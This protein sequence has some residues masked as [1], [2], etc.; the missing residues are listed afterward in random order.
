VQQNGL[1]ATVATNVAAAFIERSRVMWN[2]EPNCFAGVPM[3]TGVLI[4][5][6]R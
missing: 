4:D 1:A 3:G 2:F 5:Q 6:E